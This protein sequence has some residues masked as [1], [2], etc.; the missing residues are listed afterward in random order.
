MIKRRHQILL[1]LLCCLTLP[2]CYAQATSPPPLPQQVELNGVIFVRIPAGNFWYGIDAFDRFT[3]P[4]PGQ[5][6]HRQVQVWLDDYY[7]AKYEATASDLARFLASDAISTELRQRHLDSWTQGSEAELQTGHGCTLRLNQEGNAII[8]SIQKLP[9][10]YLSW[11]QADLF[12][13]WMGARLPTEPEWQKAARGTDQRIWPWGDTYPDDS[14]GNFGFGRRCNPSPVD[15]FPKG[16]SPYGL[17][18]MAGNVAEYVG[19]WY[20]DKLDLALK[21]NSKNP[22]AHSVGS[23]IPYD[24]PKR[25]KKGGR[26]SRDIVGHAIVA[27]NL[28]ASKNA[29]NRDGARFALDASTVKQLLAQGKAR[30]IDLPSPL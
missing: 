23:A 25:I 7:I 29:T 13:K 3:Q 14:Y 30:A 6:I 20:N 28:A 11:E 18:N 24:Q 15:Q 26:W 4:A 2:A 5:P 10:T 21:M 9:A 17:Y 16:S 12:A 19:G 8:G 22:P 27:R 1:C